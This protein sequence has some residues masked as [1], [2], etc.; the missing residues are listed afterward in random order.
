VQLL[1]SALVRT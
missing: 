1:A